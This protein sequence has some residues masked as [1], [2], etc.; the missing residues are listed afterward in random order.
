MKKSIFVVAAISIV[1]G[2]ASAEDSVKGF[3]VNKYTYAMGENYLRQWN[4]ELQAKID[5]DIEKYRKADGVFD[6]HLTPGT[7][8]KV[9]QI[10]HEFFFG[11]HIFNFNQLGSE[12]NNFAYQ[13]L[14]KNL[15]NSAT[16][17]LYWGRHEFPK[18]VSHLNL[19]ADDN[20][21]FWATCQE[22]EKQR[23]WRTPATLP[24]LEFCDTNG[25]RKHGH[26]LMWGANIILPQWLFDAIPSEITESQ[27]F[28]AEFKYKDPKTKTLG[29]KSYWCI[30]C[31]L[32]PEEFAAKYPDFVKEV[33]DL[34]MKRVEYICKTFPSRFDSFDVVNESTIDTKE[35]AYL[36]GGRDR[37]SPKHKV[38]QSAYG[39]MP[40]DY[41]Y[42]TFDLAKKLL[43][44]NTKL[45]INDYDLTQ[46]YFDNIRSL[47]DR[48]AKIDAVGMQMHIFSAK[49]TEKAALGE[50]AELDPAQWIK[51]NEK[52]DALNLPYHLSEITI[53]APTLDERGEAI[54]AVLAYNIYRLWFS[55]KNMN[56]ITWWNTVDDTYLAEKF[57]SGILRR[58]M[59]KKPVY[60]ALDD[61]INRQWKTN[62]EV[63]A[64]KDGKISFRG[65]KGTYKLSWVENSIVMEKIVSVK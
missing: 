34:F 61:L 52:F 6:L 53:M 36:G 63:K 38:C 30:F 26:P 40:S 62:C 33:D 44:P 23:F 27:E 46:D 65:F 42:R 60:Y 39:I 24:I 37:L 57:H 56:G 45:Y 3:D 35:L 8:V 15:F 32:S 54:Q 50:L 10:K 31:K 64:D 2:I 11:A 12:E 51:I 25:I 9:E 22:P 59:S 41:V 43:S 7:E 4:P 16:I 48:G 17:P 28:Q 55:C 14:W 18:G 1:C 5:A 29:V 58:D 49:K 47:L 20:P 21:E 19:T 13:A